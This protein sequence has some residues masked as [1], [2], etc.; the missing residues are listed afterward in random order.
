MEEALAWKH[1]AIEQLTPIQRTFWTLLQDQQNRVLTPTQI[2]QKAGYKTTAPWYKA[3]KD[4]PFRR[5]IESLGMVAYHEY[6][7]PE[8]HG[9]IPL[10]EHPDIEWEKDVVDVRRLVSDYPKHLSA[11]S[12]KL[13]FSFLSNQA[14]KA[15]VKRYFRARLGF[16]QP[17]SLKSYLGWI[18]PFMWNLQQMYPDL[19]SFAILTRAIMASFW[20]DGRGRKYS[21]TLLGRRYMLIAAESMFVY[22]QRHEWEEAPRH[23]LFYD[24]DRPSQPRKRPPLSQ[25]PF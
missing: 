6:H 22:M 11:A 9:I 16:W 12:F 18:R 20:M 19:A 15:V 7:E 10:T 14:L 24:E 2:T 5:L 17:S 23:C 8:Q 21:I 3:L 13:N 1:I 4:E 25:K